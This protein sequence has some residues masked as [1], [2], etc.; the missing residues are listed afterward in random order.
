MGNK[1]VVATVWFDRHSGIDRYEQYARVWD[2]SARQVFGDSAQIMNIGVDPPDFTREAPVFHRG[3]RKIGKSKTLSWLEK[4]RQWAMII[5]SI[6]EGRPILMSDIDVMF[7]S[8]PFS[9]LSA[10][11]YDVGICGNNTGLVYFSGSAESHRF[12]VRWLEATEYLFANKELYKQYDK[13]YK[14]LDQGSMGYLLESGEHN[15]NVVQLPR[16]FHS[17]V[18]HY[19]LPCHVMHYHSRLRAVIFGDKPNSILPLEIVPYA[20]AWRD[21]NA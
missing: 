3:A 12:M 15:A 18:E 5:G 11:N 20:D 21:A 1:P 16:R 17:T 7:F 2:R 13:K 6:P 9:D 14:G 4:I 19:S 8:D 10:Y